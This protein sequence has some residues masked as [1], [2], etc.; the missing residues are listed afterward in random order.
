M[1]KHAW[2]QATNRLEL[3]FVKLPVEQQLQV[4][5]ELGFVLGIPYSCSSLQTL[6][7]AA[8]QQ[9][10]NALFDSFWYSKKYFNKLALATQ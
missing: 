10:P 9:R 1:A 7:V 4:C 3:G 5:L 8:L 6:R 2:R